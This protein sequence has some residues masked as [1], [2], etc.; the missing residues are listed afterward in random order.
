MFLYFPGH[1]FQDINVPFRWFLQDFQLRMSG[2]SCACVYSLQRKSLWG[3]WFSRFLGFSLL[4]SL[5]RCWRKQQSPLFECETEYRNTNCIFTHSSSSMSLITT[6]Y[7]ICNLVRPVYGLMT[8]YNE[9]LNSW[10][11]IQSSCQWGASVQRAGHMIKQVN[12]GT[13]CRLLLNQHVLP[14]QHEPTTHDR[15]RFRLTCVCYITDI[16]WKI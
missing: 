12:K 11:I 14:C 3:V 8:H 5:Y 16:L 13:S 10:L 6:S 15:Q 4:I 9:Y 7:L 2:V 1:Y